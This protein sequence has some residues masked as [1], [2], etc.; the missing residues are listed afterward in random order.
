MSAGYWMWM[1]TKCSQQYLFSLSPL[2]LLFFWFW[3]FFLCTA[4]CAKISF[5]SITVDFSCL[6]KSSSMCFTSVLQPGRWQV[7]KA[8]M[9]EGELRE[10][11]KG[12]SL[13]DPRVCGVFWGML[14]SQGALWNCPVFCGLSRRLLRAQ[15]V[16]CSLWG[17]EWVLPNVCAGRRVFMSF[18]AQLCL[19]GLF[20]QQLAWWC[21]HAWDWPSKSDRNLCQ[22]SDPWAGELWQQG[23][24]SVL[25][26]WFWDTVKMCCFSGIHLN[27]CW[28]RTFGARSNHASFL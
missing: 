23:R 22:R 18:M 14:L 13:P 27:Y 19:L 15:P 26:C 16:C 28:P 25:S 1:N 17:W 4:V 9:K 10:G 7:L 3:F 20:C 11:S 5:F 6:Q 12:F 8:N 24:A 21:L 2:P